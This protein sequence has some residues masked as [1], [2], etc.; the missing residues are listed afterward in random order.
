MAWPRRPAS[1]NVA[2]PRLRAC[3]YLA[4]PCERDGRVILSYSFVLFVTSLFEPLFSGSWLSRCFF[5]PIFLCSLCGLSV[6]YMCIIL[7]LLD[8]VSRFLGLLV[9]F[10]G[11][12]G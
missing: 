1:D 12:N 10:V 3:W 7:G 4:R 5:L 6:L 2:A 9:L 11:I 8:E